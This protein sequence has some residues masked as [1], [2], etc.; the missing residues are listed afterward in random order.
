MVWSVGARG[1]RHGLGPELD[2]GE[3]LSYASLLAD[4]ALFD[5]I[6]NP[7]IIHVYT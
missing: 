6:S 5:L 1:H 4:R 3:G 2:G 7:N